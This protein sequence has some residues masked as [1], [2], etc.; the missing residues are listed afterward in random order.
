MFTY[1]LALLVNVFSAP[2]F[3]TTLFVIAGLLGLL[4]LLELFSVMG[5]VEVVC[6]LRVERALVIFQNSAIL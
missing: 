2:P 4:V 1:L 5:V 6:L 3:L